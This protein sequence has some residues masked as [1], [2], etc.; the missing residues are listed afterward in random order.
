MI[1]LLLSCALCALLA[2]PALAKAP[3]RPPSDTSFFPYPIDSTVLPNGLTVVRVHYPSPGLVAYYSLVRV[4]SRNEVEPGRTGFAHFFE[5]MMFR[6]TARFPEGARE[7]FLESVGIAD[8]AF[9]TDDFTLFHTFGPSSALE[10]L[11]DVEADRFEHLSYDE[12][13]FQT[14]AKA[15]LGEYHKDAAGPELKVDETLVSTAFTRHPYSH[16]TLGFLKDVEA[17]PQEYDYSKQFFQRWY[18]PDNV[19][20]FVVGD[21]D[22]AKVMGWIQDKY[23]HWAGRSADVAIPAEP[24]QAGQR[25]AE[26]RWPTP[27]L[28]RLLNA[29]HVP[30]ASLKTDDQ[31]IVEVL[32]PYLAGP[33]S[34]LYHQLVLEKQWAESV[35]VD[36]YAHRDPNLLTLSATLKDPK[37]LAPT[38]EA[39]NKQ[40]KGL[41]GGK[42]DPKRIEAIKSN[43]RYAV[44]MELDSPD[45]VAQEL[46][47]YA[48]AFGAPDSLPQLF[49]HIKA[50]KPGMIQDF[51]KRYLL[52]SNRTLLVLRSTAQEAH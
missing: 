2:A 42:L 41:V 24:K 1:R 43:L 34:P 13:T 22:D 46:A 49:N 37:Y 10:K 39:F 18:T 3:A 50:V 44:L 52:A 26:V 48:G 11:I 6:G 28:A 40:V 45:K 4:G 29:W 38:Q 33:T 47:V 30:A 23:G 14:E 17:M 31:A 51:A 20:L 21:F 25:Q 19:M 32:G 36:S 8:N 15:V 7:K 12:P 35:S 16:T 9:T 5:H 27:T